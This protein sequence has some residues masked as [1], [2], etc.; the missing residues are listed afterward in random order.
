MMKWASG[1][2]PPCHLRQDSMLFPDKAVG[3]QYVLILT[4]RQHAAHQLVPYS[5]F[6]PVFTNVADNMPRPAAA[7]KVCK[8]QSA[9]L[10]STNLADCPQTASRAVCPH[11]RRGGTVALRCSGGIVALRC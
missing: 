1:C 10:T 5:R 7:I 8:D 4:R 9:T 2:L 3:C 6:N 11:C